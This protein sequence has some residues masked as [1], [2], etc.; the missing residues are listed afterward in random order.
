MRVIKTTYLLL[1]HGRENCISV[2]KFI[3]TQINGLLEEYN[4]NSFVYAHRVERPRKNAFIS[5]KY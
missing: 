5:K 3:Q 4:M 2:N 1:N